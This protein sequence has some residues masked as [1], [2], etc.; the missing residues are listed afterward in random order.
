MS[1]ASV[2]RLLGVNARVVDGRLV[3]GP[4]GEPAKLRLD[5]TELVVESPYLARQRLP[6]RF[7]VLDGRLLPCDP[8]VRLDGEVVELRCSGDRLPRILDASMGEPVGRLPAPPTELEPSA[9]VERQQH[10]QHGAHHD[11]RAS[12]DHHAAPS[13]PA[14]AP[15]GA[16][17]V[18]PPGPPG[19]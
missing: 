13:P 14:A 1:P 2:G 19:G 10:E 11:D 15:A 3:V 5:G 6:H 8:E 7:T 12:H 4:D 16:V 17:A 18:P 9:T